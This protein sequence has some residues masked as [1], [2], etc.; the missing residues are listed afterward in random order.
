MSE[1]LI[2]WYQVA[3]WCVAVPAT[4]FPIL[5]TVWFRWW[6]SMLGRALFTKS[7]ALMIVVDLSLGGAVWEWYYPRLS[8]GL[9]FG[10][11]AALVF[12]QYAMFRVKMSNNGRRG[13]KGVS[14]QGDDQKRTED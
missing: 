4:I 7:V 3:L 9:L 6:E 14:E 11:A 5:Y 1:R 13:M 12:Q 10:L 2:F 8:I